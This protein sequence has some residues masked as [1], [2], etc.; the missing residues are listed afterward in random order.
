MNN[1]TKNMKFLGKIHYAWIITISALLV[2]GFGV[3]IMSSCL[4]VF[5]VPVCEAL[6]FSRGEFT[7]YNSIS[8]ITTLLLM[9]IFGTL[10]RK[11]GFRRL[12]FVGAV[13]AGITL[14]GYSFSTKLWQFYALSFFSGAFINGIG[15]MS[16]GILINQWFIDKRGLATG[17]AFSGTGLIAAFLIPIINNFIETNGWAWSYRFLACLSFGVLLPIILFIIKDKPE[18]IGLEPYRNKQAQAEEAIVNNENIGV[19][20]DTAMRTSAFWFLIIAVL[21]IAL[22]QAGPH[23]HTTSFLIDSGYTTAHASSVYSTYMLLLTLSKIMMGEIFDRLG[24]LKGSL[25]IGGCCVIFPI[26]ALFIHG[27]FAP[28]LYVFTLALASSGST[29]LG[30]ILTTNY[31]G[32]KDFSRIYSM[33]SMATSI[34]VIISSPFLGMIFDFTGGYALAW[35]LVIGMG[36]IVCLCLIGANRK[37]KTLTMTA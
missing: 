27:S 30:T 34:G 28:W 33:V 29:I 21:G 13:A 18:D 8:G 22:C 20:R 24:S 16:L 31:F 6:G 3:G 1:Q 4:G 36:T 26:I 11:F 15:I 19:S 37:S 5:V 32:R 35:Y 23:I 17:L 9:P 25:L 12:A 10:F 14:L 2:A 7:L